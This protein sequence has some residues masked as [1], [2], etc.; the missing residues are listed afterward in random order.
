VQLERSEW[1][2]SY[3][4]P[5]FVGNADQTQAEWR[6]PSFK[7]ALRHWWRIVVGGQ[8]PSLRV[9]E[10]RE[11]EAELFGYVLDGKACKSKVI[12]AFRSETKATESEWPGCKGRVT[13]GMNN[14]RPIVSDAELYLGYGPIQKK[15]GQPTRP[16]L[17]LWIR[18]AAPATILMQAPV[19]SR[20]DLL[21]T[22]AAM[23]HFAAMGGRNRRSWGSIKLQ[24]V[25]PHELMHAEELVSRCSIS[26][27]Q[28][29][30]RDW[31][32]GLV[33]DDEGHPLVWETTDIR[34]TWQDCVKDL[35][36]TLRECN[37]K[38]RAIEGKKE[39]DLLLTTGGIQSGGRWASPLRMKVAATEN[40]LKLRLI[41][42]PCQVPQG[43]GLRELKKSQC[44]E[45]IDFLDSQHGYRRLEK[46]G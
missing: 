22:F 15:K 13:T 36:P 14:G 2:L 23:N 4:M 39:K 1:Q 19:S 6:I 7:G 9:S 10:L 27:D 46:R 43:S 16:T 38:A 28:A 29:L 8:N 12:L 18:P 26:L 40:G 21:M 3:T 17:N 35:G 37:V 33:C 41:F 42:L 32:S 24:A 44:E 45:M 34:S 25:T 5:A 11:R 30:S 31:V 20:S